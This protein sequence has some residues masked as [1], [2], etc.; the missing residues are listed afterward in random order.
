MRLRRWHRF[1]SSRSALLNSGALRTGSVLLRFM[2]L[3]SGG[4][5]LQALDK[6]VN[7]TVPTDRCR[8]RPPGGA[9]LLLH[10]LPLVQF[11]GPASKRLFVGEGGQHAVMQVADMFLSGGIVKTDQRQATGHG[12][13]HHI[14]EG[15]GFTG[16]QKD[17]ATGVVL[18]QL[19]TAA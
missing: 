12:F 2:I 3:Y 1:S 7:D 8:F 15:V 13:G 4:A 6:L 19:F 18:R 17:I 14:A 10:I 11:A 16:E 9:H 5:A